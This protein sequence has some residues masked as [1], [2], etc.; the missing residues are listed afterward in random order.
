MQKKEFA[1]VITT[2]QN[3]VWNSDI[4]TVKKKRS[5]TTFATRSRLVFCPTKLHFA[6]N[7]S[8]P[9]LDWDIITCRKSLLHF[10]YCWAIESLIIEVGQNIS[11]FVLCN[12]DRS[13]L[14]FILKISF[15]IPIEAKLFDQIPSGDIIKLVFLLVSF[16]VSEPGYSQVPNKRVT[17]LTIAMFSS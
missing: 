14:Y 15:K 16:F 17:R 4:I 1:R 5:F 13:C 2:K 7:N 6:Q 10:I 11:F 3:T 8:G 12:Q 9:D